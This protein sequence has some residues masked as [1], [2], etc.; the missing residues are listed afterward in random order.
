MLRN[1]SVH[2]RDLHIPL[3]IECTGFYQRKVASIITSAH[4]ALRSMAS[5]SG[6]NHPAESTRDRV[7][8]SN[9]YICGVKQAFIKKKS[10]V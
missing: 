2:L 5:T 10:G 1:N 9:A 3:A 8:E 7:E 4:C 6:T